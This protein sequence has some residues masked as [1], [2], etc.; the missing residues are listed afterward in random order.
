MKPFL[1]CLIS[2]KKGFIGRHDAATIGSRLLAAGSGLL[3]VASGLLAVGSELLVVGLLSCRQ[4]AQG[5][6]QWPTISS[7]ASSSE[8]TDS[9]P[10]ATVSGL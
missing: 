9:S 3:A 10:E 6:Y 2:C 1:L 4:W 8:A 7:I 5:G